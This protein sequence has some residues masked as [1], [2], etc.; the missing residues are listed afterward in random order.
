LYIE[1][2]SLDGAEINKVWVYYWR[3]GDAMGYYLGGL[4]WQEILEGCGTHYVVN[5][6]SDYYFLCNANRHFFLETPLLGEIDWR[7]RWEETTKPRGGYFEIN[8]CD[9]CKCTAAYCSHGDAIPDPEWF[10]G[11][12]IDATD[13]GH[14]GIY[15]LVIITDNYAKKFGTP[16]P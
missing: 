8:V 13:T 9:V 16:P 15:D 3:S 5:I 2:D 11:A 1:T 10:P 7:W 6:D 4:P 12:D 14:V